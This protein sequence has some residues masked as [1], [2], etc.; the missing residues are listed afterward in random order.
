[1]TPT[2]LSKRSLSDLIDII[3]VQPDL[4]D[5]QKRDRVSAIKTAAKAIGLNPNDIP[6]EVKLLR[7]KLEEISPEAIGLSRA[8]WNNVRSLFRASLELTTELMPSRQSTPVLA[9]WEN[10]VSPLPRSRRY[11]V[12]P[13]LRYLSEKHISPDKV[14]LEDIEAFRTQIVE[15]RLRANPEKTWDGMIWAWNNCL[16]EVPGWPHFEIPREDQRVVYVRQW[17]DFPPSLKEDVDLYLRRLAGIDIQ[18]DGPLRAARPL[19]LKSREYLLRSAASALVAQG[20]AIESLRSLSD[21]ARFEP[22]KIV[23]PYMLNRGEGKHMAGAFNIANVL[24]AAAQHYVRVDAAELE[25]IKKAVAKFSP[26]KHGMTDKNRQRLMPF[27]DPETVRNFLDLPHRLAREVKAHGG[28]TRADAVTAQIA[29]AIA[30]LQ[31]VPLRM[32]NLTSLDLGEHIV[33]RAG[34]VFVSI[35]YDQVKN[36][37]PIEMELPKEVADLIAWY[38]RE[39]RPILIDQPS[40][41]LFPGP[42]GGPKEASTLS[43]QISQKTKRYLGLEMH[44]HLFRHVAVKLYLDQR[45]G[46]YEVVRRVLGHKSL[47]T[48]TAFYAGAEGASAGRHFQTVVSGLRSQPKAPSRNG[49][50]T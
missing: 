23:L 28:N 24:K 13:M 30:I 22:M 35:P 15:N 33:E 7:R 2:T 20:V 32:Q 27:N 26:G 44:P 45:P 37:L 39:F 40:S 3:Q 16:K 47:A 1:M 25:K 31:A 18:E 4:T 14:T 9:S 8:R 6:L 5:I 21:I 10:L 42:D 49:S 38:Y 46:E 19:T 36:A 29:V 48:T 41:A 50:R 43:R 11:R 12:L 34:R 17:S